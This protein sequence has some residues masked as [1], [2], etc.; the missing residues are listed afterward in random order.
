MRVPTFV[1][2]VL[3]A[4]AP[5]LSQAAVKQAASD[6]LLIQDSRVLHVTPTKAYAALSEV[7][8]WW[9]SEHTWSGNAANLSLK[10]EA[11][12]CF[13]ERWND[14]SVQ[15]MQVLGAIKDHQ[16]RLQGGLG[17]LQGMAVQGVMTFTLKSAGD[18]STL[19]FEYR[20]NGASASGLDKL[21]AGVDSVLMQQLDRLQR[22]AET[23]KADAAKP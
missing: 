12:G 23:G 10:A 15:H 7:A 20:V 19:S 13:C 9:D 1:V 21:A 17:P 5:A 8:H 3:L 11:G 6:S 14:N 2:F 18:G 22:Y 4:I 16:L